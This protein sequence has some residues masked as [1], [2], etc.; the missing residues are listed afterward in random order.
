MWRLTHFA[1]AF[2]AWR[3]GDGDAGGLADLASFRRGAGDRVRL[4]LLGRE[5][6]RIALLQGM[7]SVPQL[8]PSQTK[9]TCA[10]G[11]TSVTTKWQKMPG[12]MAVVPLQDPQF[13]TCSGHILGTP[14]HMQYLSLAVWGL[15]K[16]SV[17]VS[18]S[19][20]AHAGDR[21]AGGCRS[22]SVLDPWVD[23]ACR[24][25]GMTCSNRSQ[26]IGAKYS[27]A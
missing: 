24:R 12:T 26:D 18:C 5:L 14:H 15:R 10:H 16:V 9:G 17:L 13:L 6:Q 23:F 20:L 21:A 1:V 25:A 8:I 7:G 3:E 11:S 2:H 4:V 27:W 19:S 22:P